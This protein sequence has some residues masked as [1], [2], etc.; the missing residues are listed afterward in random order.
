MQSQNLVNSQP[1][2]H[3]C[4]VKNPVRILSFGTCL[5]CGA[6]LRAKRTKPP[7][8]CPGD[9]CRIAYSRLKASEKIVGKVFDTEIRNEAFSR[10]H[11]DNSSIGVVYTNQLLAK[12][13]REGMTLLTEPVPSFP[14]DLPTHDVPVRTMAEHFAEQSTE[15]PFKRNCAC[16]RC[17][18]LAGGK[19]LQVIADGVVRYRRQTRQEVS[20]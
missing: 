16:I 20:A 9:R 2:A 1:T 3:V 17:Y 13:T 18:T 12:E 6:P 19:I 15:H 14:V 11:R 5:N 4:P 8:F 7:K 10:K